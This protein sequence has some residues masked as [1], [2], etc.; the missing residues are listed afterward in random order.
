MLVNPLDCAEF[1]PIV[2]VCRC[3]SPPAVEMCL[4]IVIHLKSWFCLDVVESLVI[5]PAHS[6]NIPILD[7]LVVALVAANAL[8]S[9]NCSSSLNCMLSG[10]FGQK[11][12]TVAII[13]CGSSNEYVIFDPV[14]CP[15]SYLV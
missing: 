3:T 2:L 1:S 13:S 6:R 9:T 5:H 14:V 10:I 8:N 12:L 15:I 4:Q 11:F 7:G